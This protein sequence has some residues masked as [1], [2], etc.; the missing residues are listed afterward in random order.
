MKWKTQLSNTLY[1]GICFVYGNNDFGYNIS[2]TTHV[3]D[4]Y[5]INYMNE[6]SFLLFY[7]IYF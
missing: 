2:K 5:V 7:C 4:S 3:D 6:N 1:I